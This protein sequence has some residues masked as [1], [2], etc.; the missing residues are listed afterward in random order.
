MASSPPVPSALPEPEVD[1]LS[2]ATVEVDLGTG[3]VR[4]RGSG[5]DRWLTPRERALLGFLVR[6]PDRSFDR[7]ALQAGAWG[8]AER[9]VPSRGVDTAIRRLR[10]KIEANP[11]APD[12]VLTT[13]GV[14][15]R[16]VAPTGSRPPAPSPPPRRVAVGAWVVDLELQLLTGG[17]APGRL[18][19]TTREAEVLTLL[20]DRAPRALGRTEAH[21]ALWGDARGGERYLDLIVHHLR[22][23]L[24]PDP[25]RP[26]VLVTDAHT[27][28]RLVV[29]PESDPGP[30]PE[31]PERPIRASNLGAPVDRWFG[32]PAV[33]D[34]VAAALGPR[35]AVATVVGP[36]G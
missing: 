23:K 26:T 32:D 16:F 36:P 2:L 13:H 19:L 27:G 25:A 35:G 1:L 21:R 8:L 17:P 5:P 10:A 6:H 24:E 7:D 14:G 3:R 9:P 15:Y 33:R 4:P 12:H 18:P 34:E 22:R 30:R 20:I 31:A 28:Y 11:G 29:G